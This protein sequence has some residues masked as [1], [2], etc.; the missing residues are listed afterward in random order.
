MTSTSTEHRTQPSGDKDRG[1]RGRGRRRVYDSRT[2]LALAP[3]PLLLAAP[4]AA[5]DTAP[6]TWSDWYAM[7]GFIMHL[8]VAASVLV[9]ALTAERAWRL[10]ARRVLPRPLLRALA[11]QTPGDPIAPRLLKAHPSSLARLLARDG[12]RRERPQEER[13]AALERDFGLECARLRE[14]LPALGAVAQLATMLGLLG[15][16][17]GMIEAFDLI[18]GSG[19]SDAR[20]VAGGIFRALVTTAAGLGVAVVAT[21][22]QALTR[23]RAER[24]ERRLGEWAVAWLRQDAE[25]ARPE[26]ASAA[27]LAAAKAS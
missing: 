7:G 12:A 17:L 22:A 3:I 19:T 21:A 14:H 11:D 26:P 2:W 13:A 23:R 1:A 4:I 20:V 8:L 27:P 6:R 5:A 15:T 24:L 10:R 9:A 25:E 16:V 18:A